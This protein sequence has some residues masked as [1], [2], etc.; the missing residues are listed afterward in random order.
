LAEVAA[1]AGATH[2]PAGALAPAL[3]DATTPRFTIVDGDAVADAAIGGAGVLY[4][5]G[6]LRVTGRLDFTGL[7]AAAGGIETAPGSTLQIC[8]GAVATGANALEAGGGGFV[9]A[10]AEAL[11]LAATLAPIPA[12]ARV[13][14]VREAP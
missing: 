12:P 5:A 11:R 6:R 4:V 2:L 1:A 3:G 14:A 10:S 8:G 7:L 13:I 9:R